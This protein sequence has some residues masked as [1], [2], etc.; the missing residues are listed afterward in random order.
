MEGMVNRDFWKG[1]RVFVTGHTG[2]KGA[3]LALWLHHLGAEVTGYSLAPHT[4]PSLFELAG[5]AGKMRSIKGDVRDYPALR[6]AL[7]ESRPEI[8]IH[9]A[10]QAIVR[11]SYQDPLE[12][13]GSN[14]M[15]TVHLLEAVRQTDG[16]RAV[17]NVTSD[18]CYDNREWLWGYRETDAMGGF[19]P[20]SSSKGCAEL[21]TAAY[22]S[23]FF[24]SA[25]PE[26]RKAG[27]AS[28]RAGNV[29]G[30]GD[31]ARDRLV[32]D[33]IR[34]FMSGEKVLIRS[35]HAVRPW[36]H[37][38]EPLCGYMML[39]EQLYQGGKECADAWN[40]GPADHEARTV[41]WVVEKTAALWGEEAGFSVDANPHPHEAHYLKLDSSKARYLLGWK[42][43]L[44][45][46]ETMDWTVSWYKNLRDNPSSAYEFT[47]GQIGRYEKRA[48]DE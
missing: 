8:V 18:K 17:V 24:A 23:S 19:D 39:A 14:V 13:Y 16:V 12:T 9:M 27:I 48:S 38:L 28:A 29:V 6:T 15:G 11:R 47:I 7:Q 46:H 44:D 34:A 2:F 22:R 40:F 31:W 37:V 25:H 1:K 4:D 3:W 35:P 21:V 20:Y 26:Q 42:P 41:S 43:C 10:A 36:Q 5:L 45:I 30:G 32:P 33:I